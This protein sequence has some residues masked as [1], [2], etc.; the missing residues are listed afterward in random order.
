MEENKKEVNKIPVTL[1]VTVFNGKDVLEI[2]EGKYRL[3][4]FGAKKARVILERI[5]EIKAFSESHPYELKVANEE[6]K[7]E[8]QLKSLKK[9]DLLK[10][11]L[12]KTK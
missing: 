3:L 10:L 8:K 2:L 1:N 4:S 9:E 12:A 5:D 7:K 6:D 11:L